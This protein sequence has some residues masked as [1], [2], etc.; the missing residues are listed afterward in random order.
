M[1][2]NKANLVHF[3]QTE[4]SKQTYATMLSSA[5]VYVCNGNEC[6]K[7]SA[8]NLNVKCCNVQELTCNH[9]EADTRMLFHASHA[10]KQGFKT[11]AIRS[12]D[13]DVAVLACGFSHR[14]PATA[15]FHTGSK[16]R[17][18]YINMTKMGQCLESPVCSALI[19]LHAFTGCD[20][21]S[22]FSGRG[23]KSGYNIVTKD[24]A[25]K[26]RAIDVVGLWGQDFFLASAVCQE[27]EAFTCWLYEKFQATSI[28]EVR[29][30]LFSSRLSSS[31]QLPPTQDGLRQHMLCPN[32][33]CGIWHRALE[34]TLHLCHLLKGLGG[35]LKTALS[36]FIGWTNCLHLK[37]YWKWSVIIVPKAA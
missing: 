12:S 8:E 35:K 3:L 25:L 28:D 10:A 30:Q 27:L 15:L 34:G 7:L 11:V 14:I 33:Q 1:E 5:S 13:T 4:W 20:T 31:T 24:S 26:Q 17:V 6:F 18:R 37:L 21:T 2:E 22:A 32:Y 23:K 19:G 16:H 36:K 29:Y 9:K